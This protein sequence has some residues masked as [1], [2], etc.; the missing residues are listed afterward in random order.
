MFGSKQFCL[1]KALLLGLCVLL[2]GCGARNKN[3]APSIEFTRVPLAGEGGPDKLDSIEGR[4][5]GARPGQR[6]V[7]FA[8]SGPWWVQ[9]L[10]EQPFTR[11][12]PDSKWRNSTHFGTE[13]A[14]LLVE[15]EYRPQAT[16]DVLPR[17]GGGVIAL[18][19]KKGRPVFWQTWW[20]LGLCCFGVLL[21]A[22]GLYRLRVRRL[23][24][25]EKH[26]EGLVNQRTME[27]KKEVEERKS[28]E[29]A[30][31]RARDEL[32][33]R[34]RQRTAEL[35]AANKALE[36]DILE[37]RRVEEQLRQSQKME[38][39]GQLA[40]GV[41]HDFN[42]LLEVIIGYSELVGDSMDSGSAQRVHIEQVRNA[43][44]HAAGLTRQLLAFSRKQM[45]QPAELDLN[46]IVAEVEKL[47]RRV[48]GAR[49]EL[50]TKLIPGLGCVLADR[51]QIEQVILNL[52]LNARDAMPEGGRLIIETANVDMDA[53]SAYKHPE[54]TPGSFVMLA[55]SDTGIGMDTATRQ[56]I[57]EPFFT[58][59]ERGKGTGLGLA[60]VYG[61]VK[62]SG[63]HIWV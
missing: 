42:N 47:L 44:E 11:I 19:I 9:P 23:R 54:A 40:G 31:R 2:A 38:A 18:A 60:T 50:V 61:I 49:I 29:E 21:S 30:L 35:A 25:R 52:C 3:A 36:A 48:I 62:Q 6:I 57:F 7:L 39:L 32:E 63:G 51:G 17:A 41:A 53:A 27:I 10:A 16:M 46:V 55:V 5:T 26:L 59:K 56:R 45:L 24:V 20:F 1:K 14:A 58:T 37:R 34:V 13:Y 8:K 22:T 4:V 28:A 33:D 15:P 12:Q 43:A